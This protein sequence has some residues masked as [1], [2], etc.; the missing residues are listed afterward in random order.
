[1]A[2]IFWSWL[3]VLQGD[4]AGAMIQVRAAQ[5]AEPLSP[6]VMGTVAHTYFLARRYDDAIAECEKCLEIDPSFILGI[7]VMGMCRALQ[8]RLVEAV[9]IGKRTVSMSGRAPFYL[10]ILGHY[11]ARSGATDKVREVLDEL[12]SLADQRYV[13][14][15][16]YVV[17]YAG[18]N[19]ID[20]AFEW[21]T[22][23]Y[24]DGASPFNYCTPLIENLQADPRHTAELR[25]MAARDW[26]KRP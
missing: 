6:L 19:D 20:R 25:P 7:H 21:Q 3:M 15:H 26:V 16:C 9:E 11:Y 22:K 5:E 4:I 2:R 12:E 17:I 23:A 14:P 24:D 18:L 10:G 8:G 13:P 1:M